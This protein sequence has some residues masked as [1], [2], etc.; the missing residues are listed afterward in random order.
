[1]LDNQL[2]HE[3]TSKRA[4]VIQHVISLCESPE[5]SIMV[6]YIDQEK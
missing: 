1:M 4:V 5:D 2:S 6:A 3:L